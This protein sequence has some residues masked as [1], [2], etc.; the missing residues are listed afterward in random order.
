MSRSRPRFSGIVAGLAVLA[1]TPGLA[2][3]Y[4]SVDATVH[5]DETVD[6]DLTYWETLEGSFR[7]GLPAFETLGR[8][9]ISGIEGPEVQRTPLT[10]PVAPD[11]FGCH[12]T[13]RIRLGDTWLAVLVSH[14]DGRF[15]VTLPQGAAVLQGAEA[16]S[17]IRVTFPGSV[18]SADA[19]LSVRG[20]TVTWESGPGSTP[21]E[22]HKSRTIVVARDGSSPAA[23]LP[24]AAA[25]VVA[26]LAGVVAGAGVVWAWARRRRP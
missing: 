15:V 21:Q 11:R 7:E 24:D 4:A 23:G 10:D 17:H 5:P 12:I 14:A 25:P 22:D 16:G 26:T 9:A 13:G 8:C 18:S 19:S 20:N 1:L 6:L 2:G 3:C